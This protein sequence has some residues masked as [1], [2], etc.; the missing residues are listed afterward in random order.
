MVLW[1]KRI[2]YY[3]YIDI[4]MFSFLGA[5]CVSTVSIHFPCDPGFLRKELVRFVTLCNVVEAET[6]HECQ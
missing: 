1:S 4:N 5:M 2:I 6:L 3:V